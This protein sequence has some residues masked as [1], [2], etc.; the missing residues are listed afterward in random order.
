MIEPLPRE[1]VSEYIASLPAMEQLLPSTK[2]EIK[3]YNTDFLSLGS[4]LAMQVTILF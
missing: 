1:D 4:V 2:K 3:D